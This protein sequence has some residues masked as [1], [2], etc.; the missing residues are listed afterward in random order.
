MARIGELLRSKKAAGRCNSVEEAESGML[1]EQVGEDEDAQVK[2]E[3]D[4][5][6]VHCAGAAG[7][8]C[9]VQQVE[10]V[11]QM[12]VEV[13]KEAELQPAVLLLREEEQGN[14]QVG[15]DTQAAQNL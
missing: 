3:Q 11:V 14:M 2:S 13:V 1:E 9:T 15:Q 10:E 7:T 8:L 12:Q 5:E 6:G 4:G